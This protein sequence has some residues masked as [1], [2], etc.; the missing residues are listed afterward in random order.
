M[1]PF[2]KKISFL[3]RYFVYKKIR[4]VK[5][6]KVELELGEYNPG[7][8]TINLNETQQAVKVGKEVVK[9]ISENKVRKLNKKL[10]LIPGT[11]AIDEEKLPEPT[12]KKVGTKSKK[13]LIIAEENV[14]EPTEK[15]DKKEKKVGTKPKKKLI[16]AEDE[17]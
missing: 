8:N 5:A 17:E 7:E 16:I 11:E 15:K 13:K 2:E 9:Q 6:D 12:E 1:T 4:H 14:K 10:L 3:N